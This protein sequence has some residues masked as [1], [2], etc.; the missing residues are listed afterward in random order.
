[1]RENFTIKFANSFN[2]NGVFVIIICLIISAVI[3]YPVMGFNTVQSILSFL[4]L[5]FIIYVISISMSNENLSNELPST[6]YP[7]PPHTGLDGIS[8]N[9][10]VAGMSV[11]KYLI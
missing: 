8:L 4:L 1:M 9:N 5:F 11:D 6:L 2:F 10:Y 7:T 3:I